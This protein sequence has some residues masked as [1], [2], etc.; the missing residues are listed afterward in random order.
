MNLRTTDTM[1]NAG[2]FFG[3]VAH[4]Q[5][6]FDLARDKSVSSRIELSSEIGSMLSIDVSVRES[7]LIADVLID[8]MRQAEIDLRIAISE[9][10]ST[11][12]KVPLRLILQLTNDDIRVAEPVLRS[13][14]A[15]C[16][17][18]LMY[19]I[20]SRT[21]EYWRVIA[22]R[23][24]L[25]DQVVGALADTGD[26][27][28][29]LNLVENEGIVLN[30][31]VLVTLSS[32]AQGQ[33]SLALPLLR[34]EEVERDLALTLYAHVGQQVKDFISQQYNE[35]KA[36]AEVQK[37]VDSVLEEFEGTSF[38]GGAVSDEDL[39]ET[40]KVAKSRGLLNLTSLMTA[41]RQKQSRFFAVQLSVHTDLPI[42]KI[43][44]ALNQP[45]G[46]L[47]ALI[48]KGYGFQKQDFV[49]LYTLIV[50]MFNGG[51]ITNS[52]SVKKAVS[53]Y[54]KA[55]CELARQILKS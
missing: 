52:D 13:S 53:Y 46:Q 10:L 18:D 4:V 1:S 9:K 14:C 37:A 24:S 32:L 35:G 2:L 31:A 17:F 42:R 3:D 54:D 28:T 8:L 15:L 39:F 40:A 36:P 49:S 55:S 23:K 26:F 50:P 47:F 51:Q 5:K 30:E 6:L 7:E 19:I 38:S 21:A 29:A 43:E 16:E 41:L 12:E 27:D 45:S 22:Q 25:T 44:Q 34:R 48:A 33:D 11:L 20:K